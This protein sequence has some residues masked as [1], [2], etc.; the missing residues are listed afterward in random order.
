MGANRVELIQLSEVN[1]C[2]AALL[3]HLTTT[4]LCLQ[5]RKLALALQYP[6]PFLPSLLTA[7]LP[8]GV[9]ASPILDPIATVG[10]EEW[11]FKYEDQV[12]QVN[13]VKKSVFFWIA[14]HSNC[15]SL[16]TAQ[17][18]IGMLT[19]TESKVAQ[20]V[21]IVIKMCM[22]CTESKA[23]HMFIMCFNDYYSYYKTCTIYYLPKKTHGVFHRLQFLNLIWVVCWYS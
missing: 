4:C 19:S 10:L 8:L 9:G 7:P 20:I 23:A 13:Q 12:I 18:L 11:G 16:C 5:R 1:C 6:C 2:K 15:Q 22:E 3:S 17:L 14:V 21:C